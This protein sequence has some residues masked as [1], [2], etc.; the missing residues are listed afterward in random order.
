MI[1]KLLFERLH[2]ACNARQRMVDV[3][4]QERIVSGSVYTRATELVVASVYD[5]P[6]NRAG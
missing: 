2:R 6:D 1:P 5:G 3:K 4:Q